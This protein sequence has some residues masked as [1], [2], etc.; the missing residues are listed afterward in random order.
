MRIAYYYHQGKRLPADDPGNNPYGELLCTSLERLG[1]QVEFEVDYSQEYLRR[2]QGR[3]D[4]LHFNWPHH[5]YYDDDASVMARQMQDFVQSLEK[6]RELGYRVVWTAHNLYPHNRT[7]QEIDHQF[8]LALCRLCTAVIAHCEVAAEAVTKTFGPIEDLF[9]IPHGHFVGVHSPDVTREQAR[10]ELGI[11][12]DAFVCGFFGG[13]Q[14][15]KGV[16]RLMD[17]IR[18]LPQEDSW[19]A[20]AGG[21]RPEYRD[22]IQRYAQQHPR[23]VL[24]TYPRAPNKDLFLVL[25]GADVMV[26]PFIATMTSGS[27]ILALSLGK[28]VVAPAFGCLPTTVRK[29]SGIL[30]DPEQEDGL[31]QA[32]QQI[33]NWD[34][35]AA[36]K[37]AL[38]SVKRF[39]W[40]DIA[41][42][43][44]KAYR[45]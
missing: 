3:I 32:L 23:I 14:P 16:E 39:D 22:S 35:K 24:R 28:P 6:A 44:M 40:E 19:L 10:A 38:A 27:L 12:Q 42:K 21:G 20:A 31:F 17:A 18:G 25:Q 8:R 43:T 33:R 36:S 45:A 26:L 2:N 1:V 11:P 15:Y 30:Y 13:F 29:D 4:V 41:A 5:D 9:I 37:R 34:L 7:H